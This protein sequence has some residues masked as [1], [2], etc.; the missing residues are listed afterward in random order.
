VANCGGARFAPSC[1]RAT[2]AL[3]PSCLRATPA[4]YAVG[5]TGMA[6]GTAAPPPLQRWCWCGSAPL[7]RAL[8]HSVSCCGER[9]PS[10]CSTHSWKL[11]TVDAGSGLGGSATRSTVSWLKAW[12]SK[13]SGFVGS[14]DPHMRNRPFAR[15]HQHRLPLTSRNSWFATLLGLVCACSISP[16]LLRLGATCGL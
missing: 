10:P 6:V 14:I 8:L 2:P 1:L 13:I 7:G 12:S 3:A 11:N 15:T 5:I 16:V 9:V 4:G